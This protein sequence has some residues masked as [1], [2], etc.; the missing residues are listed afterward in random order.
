MDWPQIIRD[1][2]A[3]GFTQ[4]AIA[5]AVGLTQPSIPDILLGRQKSVRWEVGDAL[6]SMHQEHCGAVDCIIATL[7][8]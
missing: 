8:N 3:C 5:K 1:L 6:L 2:L 7:E 4:T